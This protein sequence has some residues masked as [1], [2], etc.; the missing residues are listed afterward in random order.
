MPAPTTRTLNEFPQST[1]DKLRYNDT[2]RQGH[3]N[4]AVFST[5]L[6]TGRVEFLYAPEGALHAPG[7][8]FVIANLNLSFL[9]EVTWPGQVDIGTGVA[10]IG[11]SSFTLEQG[12]YQNGQCVATAVTTIVQMNESTRRSHP[13]SEES[14]QR[15]NALKLAAP[16]TPTTA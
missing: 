12:I 14:L 6:E 16:P 8:A 3:V 10:D 7:C 2:D 11:R 15:L 4:N 9:K 1:F 13:L 5:L